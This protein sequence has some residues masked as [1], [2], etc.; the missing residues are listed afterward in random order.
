MEVALK[1][2]RLLKTINRITLDAEVTLLLPF[3]AIAAFFCFTL[4]S[5]NVF[6][7]LSNNAL[8]AG[9]MAFSAFTT[10]GIFLLTGLALV[11]YSRPARLKNLLW[12]PFVFGYWCL[13]S[14]LAIYAALLIL[15]KRPCR[16]VK[17]EK[18]GVVSSTMF[19]N[20]FSRNIDADTKL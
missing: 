18:S 13:Q 9:L 1:Y 19:T 17:T 2:G 5:W 8:L 3:V 12:L 16:W 6:S 10:F 4:A 20:A 11:C 15:F 7:I 14:F